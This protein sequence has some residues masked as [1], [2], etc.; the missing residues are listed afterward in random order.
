MHKANPR[1]S[2]ENIA[3]RMRQQLRQADDGW[4]WGTDPAISKD[5][6]LRAKESPDVMWRCIEAVR[7]ETL[8]IRGG[9]SDVVPQT[10]AELLA[11]R[12]PRG[13]LV[14]IDGAGHS[15]I[16]DRPDESIGVIMPFLAGNDG[17]R[18]ARL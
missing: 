9:E 8:V 7:C 18:L 15:V 17:T 16:G 2:R 11:A 1:R 5:G 10:Q 13:K 3:L 4:R 12:L 6:A 14:V